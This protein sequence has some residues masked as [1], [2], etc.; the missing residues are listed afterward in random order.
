[1]GENPSA[2]VQ[3]Q[4]DRAEADQTIQAA[5]EIS[6]P[7]LQGFGPFGALRRILFLTKGNAYRRRVEIDGDNRLTHLFWVPSR[8]LLRAVKQEGRDFWDFEITRFHF[9]RTGGRIASRL[10]ECRRRSPPSRPRYSPDVKY[11]AYRKILRIAEDARKYARRGSPENARLLLWM[12]LLHLVRYTYVRKG[13]AIPPR[14]CMAEDLRQG[15]SDL[16]SLFHDAANQQTI[17]AVLER[18]FGVLNGY[19]ADYA[20]PAWNWESRALRFGKGFDFEALVFSESGS[21]G[22]R[23]WDRCLASPA[24]VLP[25]LREAGRR[26]YSRLKELK[27]E[28]GRLARNLPGIT[29]ALVMGS[30]AHR[31]ADLRTGL[32]SDLDLVLFTRGLYLKRFFFRLQR[33]CIDGIVISEKAAQIGLEKG[34]PIV[35]MGCANGE[36]LFDG[37]GAL[38]RFQ[39]AAR[40]LCRRPPAPMAPGELAYALA[41]SQWN[42]ERL[43][44]MPNPWDAGMLF[45]LFEEFI[46]VV[47]LTTRASGVWT[48]GEQRIL[49]SLEKERPEIAATLRGF[50][51]SEGVS[52]CSSMG[53]L[54]GRLKEALGVGDRVSLVESHKIFSEHCCFDL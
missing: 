53:L 44:A 49:P 42:L 4:L 48:T 24:L 14:I 5:V 6:L 13:L 3:A 10:K 23:L 8:R 40:A 51:Q 16:V 19:E 46:R 1:M 26:N 52:F 12:A 50:L 20:W 36:I 29:G 27:E 28:I 43:K 37:R 22:W 35:V 15:R 2:S 38:H 39:E 7:G 9:D 30:G 25:S 31:E 45:L 17:E 11:L 33:V 47:Y 18:V 54:L 34:A 41:T 21:W 32:D